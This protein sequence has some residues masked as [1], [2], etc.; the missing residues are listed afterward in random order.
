MAAAS[1]DAAIHLTTPEEDAINQAHH[2]DVLVPAA[3]VF[4]DVMRMLYTMAA[5]QAR[6][7]SV[8]RFA[9]FI[10]IAEQHWGVL[11]THI[12]LY[13]TMLP[14]P[15]R[16]SAANIDRRLSGLLSKCNSG[17]DLSVRE[18]LLALDLARKTASTIEELGGRL[19]DY[20]ASRSDVHRL[21][22]AS[23]PATIDECF[24]VRL[25][26]QN[27]LLR[28]RTDL[29]TIADDMDLKLALGYFAIDHELLR[30][31][32]EVFSNIS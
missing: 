6:A 14:P 22:M 31:H 2:A 4:V 23:N 18:L 32:P 13:A 16:T 24:S 11:R 21:A 15:S 25:H 5:P 12:T 20:L 8:H 19:P 29:Q 7:V 17:P 28:A 26:L 9:E 30:Q 10:R 27:Q 3:M 1:G